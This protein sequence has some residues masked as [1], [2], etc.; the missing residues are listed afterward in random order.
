MKKQI[1][2][3]CYL[4]A[5]VSAS[6]LP[7]FD[8]FADATAGGGT[9]YTVGS[10]LSGNNQNVTNDWQLVDSNVTG[11]NPQPVIIA[12]NL[13]YPDLLV[14]ST[15]N[16]ISNTPPAAGTGGSARLN[17]R[18][19]TAPPL[20]LYSFILKVTDLTAVPSTNANNF[21]A[22]FSDTTGTQTGSLQ[23]SGGRLVIKQSGGG[24]VLGVGRGSTTSEYAYDGTVRNLGDVVYIVVSYEHSGVNTYVNLWVNP[25]AASFGA[26]SPPAPVAGVTNGSSTGDMNGG[27][28]AAFVLSCQSTTVPSCIID[29]LRV[30]T[31]WAN[32]TGGTPTFPVA[33]TSDPASRNV[34]ASDRVSFVVSSSGTTP[35]YQWRF[36]GTDLAGATNSY[37]TLASAQTNDAGSYTVRVTNSV[38][39]LT[40]APAVL[41]VS[42]AALKLYETNL[43]VVRVGDGAQTLTTSGN[44][45][46]LD[47]FTTNGVYV[48]TVFIPDSGP[49]ALI[50]AGP[51][52]SGTTLTGTALTRSLDKR[53]MTL[54][55]Y[56]AS[57]GNATAL[58]GT[59][60]AAVPRAIVTID[61]NS[62][63][64][65]AIADTAAYSLG[66]FR[67]AATDGTNN[68]WGSGSVGGTYYFGTNSAAAYLQTNFANTRSVDIFNGNLYCL[69]SATAANGLVKFTGLPTT[70][71]GT[72]ANILTGFNFV[73]TTDFA[74]DSTGN[75]VYVTVNSTIQRWSFSGSW[76]N[77]YALTLP[78]I[79]RYLTVD[80]SGAAPVIYADTADGQLFK[81]VDTGSGSAP[82][83]FASPGPNQ[84][85][86]GIRFGPIVNTAITQPVLS[87]QTV[88]DA[89]ILNWSGP[90]FLQSSTNVAGPFA[91]VGGSSPYT[92]SITSGPQQF[93]RLR[94]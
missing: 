81:I 63:I 43:V 77:D 3:M 90:F 60:S 24:Y 7:D 23:R 73:N 75:L 51:D 79:G 45:V 49:A 25:A 1:A 18:V 88:G 74:V 56:N 40:S 38:N 87:Y 39:A 82:T 80:Y 16:S 54:A 30:A 6:A 33:I 59:T 94:N 28:I 8:P 13:S 46:F 93:F 42:A 32:V 72:V 9:A 61:S 85:F 26:I 5:L 11:T 19:A 29:E 4:L 71:Q 55:G 48:N 35:T 31:N 67:G 70:D 58:Q 86:K 10:P 21:I 69:S 12:G 53:F 62:Q 52:S 84:L 36:N 37:Y 14:T 68:F 64:N 47:Q 66:H 92:N 65:M 57:L 17:L 76:A 50:E 41:S 22:G 20:A 27:S 15:G 83:L 2:G 89:L 78:A 44:S 91:D 34:K